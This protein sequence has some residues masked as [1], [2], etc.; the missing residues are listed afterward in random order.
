[1]RKLVILC[2]AVGLALAS[3]EQW[4]G[5]SQ[6]PHYTIP[7][8]QPGVFPS[9]PALFTD[10]TDTLKYDDNT[11]ASAWCQNVGGGGWGIKFISPSDNVTLAGALIHFYDGWPVPGGTKAM[12]KAFADDGVGGGPGTQLWASDTLTIS[13]GAWNYVPI[14]VPVVAS[15]F[16]I[17]YTQV[18]DNP[19]CPG[20]SID[21]NDNA[22]AHRKWSV[23]SAGVF[24]EDNTAGDWLIRAVLDW[25]PQNVNASAVWFA[26]NMTADTVP[27]INFQIRAMIR[28]LGSDTLPIGTPV[29][30]QITG[31]D[32]YAYNDTQAT[33]TALA[34]GR[35][36]QIN[37]SPA[38][39][40]PN[41][42]G[43]Y[44][45]KV[46]TEAAGE[47]WPADDTIAYQISCANWIQYVTEAKLYWISS[48]GPD[49]AVQFDPADFPGLQYPIGLQRVRAEFFLHPQ[50]PWADSS[51]QFLVYGDDG[52]TLLYESDTL[53]APPGTPGV[54]IAHTLDP[55]LVIPSGTFYVAVSSVTGNGRPTLFGDSCASI[56]HSYFGSAGGWS[57]FDL[58]ELFVSV[59][60]QSNP[61]VEDD[62]EPG[63]H[64][65][66][67]RITNYPNPVTDQVTLK[68]QV[69]SR[70]P[71]SVNLYDATGRMMRNL[72]TANAEAR[73]GTLTMDTKSLAT[74]IYLVR[75]ETAKGS[76]TRK[77]VID[78]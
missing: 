21:A 68:W 78:R 56:D 74:G 32:S 67:L 76:A 51:F 1:M 44:F 46:W 75:L 24:S 70:M 58:G 36:A 35:T 49:K 52:A 50:I 22:P 43:D 72:Y 13:M 8:P 11:P 19:N 3:S 40:I 42:V 4:I 27:N 12:V 47:M 26:T 30:L 63:I 31:P 55:M 71:V 48:A 9:S 69:P 41:V 77:L 59:A 54:P 17:F 64:S 14:S 6:N 28:N 15:N 62:L 53:E 66:S 2:L 23:D 18:G 38:W 45:I 34:H 25:T 39:H 73:V 20:L 29:R 5:R 61:G 65:P 57:P 37:F 33:T 7:D 16:Y 60:L 10:G